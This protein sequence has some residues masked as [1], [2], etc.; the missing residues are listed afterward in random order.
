MPRIGTV[1]SVNKFKNR[2]G[3]KSCIFRFLATQRAKMYGALWE[4]DRLG[5]D[6]F[7]TLLDI[8]D[9]RIS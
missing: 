1:A 4:L 8:G 3:S 9:D 5:W 2:A 7:S 6:H